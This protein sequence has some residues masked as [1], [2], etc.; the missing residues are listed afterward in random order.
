MLQR[1]EAVLREKGVQLKI[2]K[3]FLMF[4]KLIVCVCVCVYIVHCAL[5]LIR[6]LVKSSALYREYGAI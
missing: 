6:A 1:I 2:R 5:L 3:V 4:C